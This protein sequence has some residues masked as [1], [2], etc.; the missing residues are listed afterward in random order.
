MQH[1][2]AQYMPNNTERE[3]FN[4]TNR[5]PNH[6][7][8]LTLNKQ[9]R[10]IKTTTNRLHPRPSHLAYNS[11]PEHHYCTLV[12]RIPATLAFVMTSKNTCVNRFVY[13]NIQL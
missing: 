1:F 11:Q 12:Q 5:Y 3:K 9:T 8:L 13:S 4:C 10:G 2:M 7:S 6:R